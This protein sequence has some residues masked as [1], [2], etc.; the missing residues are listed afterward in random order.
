MPQKKLG[1]TGL[2]VSEFCL[3]VLPMGPMQANL[4]PETCEAIIRRAVELGVNFID[5]AEAYKTQGYIGQALK[6]FSSPVTIATKSHAET[7]DNMARSV[8]KALKELQRDVIEIY[9]L[10]AA[11]VDL[12]VFQVRAGALK[13]LHEMKDQKVIKAVGISTHDV[14]VAGLAA[15][16]DEIDVLYP[17]INK[18]GLGILN[19]SIEGM[20]EAI[21]LAASRGK[22]VYAM[23]ALAGGSLLDRIEESINWVRA[24]E[25]IHA[26]SVGVVSQEELIADLKLFG[27]AGLPEVEAIPPKS[28]KL[29]ISRFCKACG[30]CVDECP[31]HAL[32][33]GDD[34]A[35]VDHNKCLLCGYCTP[36]CPE[37]A[38]R[39]I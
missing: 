20:L 6:G 2:E 8:E 18:A 31:N 3:G 24:I 39:V 13:F 7:Y 14:R 37:F 33:I 38:I 27:V 12:D 26:V 10:H 22:G 21:N 9:H 28:K 15:E 25:G 11:R 5:T 23:K 35:V 34:K 32:S 17:I 16:R 30:T 36:H 19:G 4:P 1:N 29:F